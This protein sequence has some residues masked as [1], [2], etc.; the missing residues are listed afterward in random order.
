MSVTLT[1]AELGAVVG[2]AVVL[3]VT[4]GAAL[5]RIGIAFLAKKMGVSPSEVIAT[6]AATGTRGEHEPAS[7]SSDPDPAEDGSQGPDGRR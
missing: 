1:M 6:N 4:D 3:A 7:T 5:S 2:L